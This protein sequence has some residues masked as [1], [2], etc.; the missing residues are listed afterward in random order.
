MSSISLPHA[1][2]LP[3]GTASALL[4]LAVVVLAS[5]PAAAQ[6]ETTAAERLGIRP[7][8]HRVTLFGGWFFGE[9][10]HDASLPTP[11]LNSELYQ[12][13]IDAQDSSTFGVRYGYQFHEHWGFELSVQGMGTE[14]ANKRAFDRD[15]VAETLALTGLQPDEQ[16]ALLDRLDARSGPY[17]MDITLFEVGAVYIANPDGRWV[18][19]A[20]GG[21]GWASS[22]LDGE[23]VIFEDL[24]A[25]RQE[26][27]SDEIIVANTLPSED[28]TGGATCPTDD[29]PCVVLRSNDG[30]VWHVGAGVSYAFT[31]RVHLRLGTRVRVVENVVDPG[32]TFLSVDGTIGLS[33]WLGGS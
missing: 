26:Q 29:D 9:T 28:P 20:G 17:D 19:E 31:D 3:R 18:I 23:P 2:R 16:A 8:M 11:P 15:A 24:V 13:R 14:L 12:L 10:A 6:Q 32:D 1:T 7:G 21:V 4:T 22:S 25:S 27:S 33:F 30:L 5:R